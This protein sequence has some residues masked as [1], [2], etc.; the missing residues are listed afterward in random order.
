MDSTHKMMPETRKFKKILIANRGE[1]AC[2][3]IWTCK[4]MGIRTVAVH[5]DVDRDSLHVRFADEAACIGPAPSAQ[6]YLN[7][8]AIISAAEIF[9][10]DAIHPGY[11]FLAESSYFAEICAACNI[12]FIGPPA[13][14]ISL[15]GDKVKARRAMAQAG[16]PVLPG[17]PD[18]IT[19]EA[20]GLKLAREIGFPVIVKASAGGGG[21]GMRIVQSEAELGKALETASNEAAAAFK[22]GSVYIERY[23][24]NPRHIEIQVLAD[25]HGDCI[26]L[27]ERECSIQRRHQKLLEEAPSPVLSP[28]LRNEMGNAAVAACKKLGYASAGTVEFLLDQDNKFYFMEMNT[29]IQVEHP[30]TE[31]VTLADIVRNQIRIAEGERL[32]YK[33]EDLMIVGHAIECR[34]NAENPETFAPSPGLIT[35]FNL[36]GGPGVRVDTYVYAGYKVPPFYDSMIA[37]VI[38]HARTRDLA[39]ARMRRA[40][41]AMVIEGIKTTI[42]LHLKIMDDP[43]F[44]AGDIST[45]FME[46]FLAQDRSKTAQNQSEVAAL[47]GQS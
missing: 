28:E 43:K 29:R 15:M 44:R 18:P 27:G 13:N 10:V 37:K 3:V 19:S 42:P 45:S 25:E 36:P 30:V 5:S 2:R 1:I 31:M 8:P 6:S 22:D 17:S 38:T 35:A 9:N 12:K 21:R 32:G 47:A 46:Y 16:L 40:L 33:Q 14:I 23:I 34:I 11:G 20:E 26:H 24:Q 4:E 39:I 7:I 41:E